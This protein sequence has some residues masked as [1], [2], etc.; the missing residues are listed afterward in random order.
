MRNIVDGNDLK[1]SKTIFIKR[2][3]VFLLCFWA[4]SFNILL[5]IHVWNEPTNRATALMTLGLMIVWIGTCGSLILYL[6]KSICS[7]IDRLPINCKWKF[8]IFCTL[9]ALLEEAFATGLTNAA[10]AFGV[11]IGDTYITASANYLDVIFFHS[12]VV[13]IPMFIAWVFLL[14]R[15]SFSAF[16]VFLHFGITGLLAEVISFGPMGVI[17]AGFWI[18]VYGLMIYIPAHILAAKGNIKPQLQHS[19]LAIIFP[20]LCSVPVSLIVYWIH[21]IRIHF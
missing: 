18:L 16:Q 11:P 2:L 21:P 19:L 15:Y 3:F 9:F 12:V 13:F 6:R 8:L 17:N 4:S 5:L 7:W 20:L 10:P 14:H 1:S